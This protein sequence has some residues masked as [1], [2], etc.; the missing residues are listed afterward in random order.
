[1]DLSPPVRVSFVHL[2]HNPNMWFLQKEATTCSLPKKH[3]SP[4]WVC[5]KCW[6]NLPNEIAIFHMDNLISKT[7]GYNGV[8]TTFSDKPIFLLVLNSWIFMGEWMACLEDSSYSSHPKKS[9]RCRTSTSRRWSVSPGR[10][11]KRSTGCAL[12]S[13]ERTWKMAVKLMGKLSSNN[14]SLK[15]AIWFFLFICQKSHMIFSFHSR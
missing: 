12:H 11:V 7:I 15:K 6:V 3:N 8:L 14:S 9:H 13:A 10:S 5:W 2:V 1:M 4:I